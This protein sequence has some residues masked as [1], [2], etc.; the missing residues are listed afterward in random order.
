MRRTLTVVVLIM[1]AVGI[2]KASDDKPAF[3]PLKASKLT[4]DID[5]SGLFVG[6]DK[7][8]GRVDFSMIDPKNDVRL[9]KPKDSQPTRVG[10]LS[11]YANKG[12]GYT[13][14]E[15][16]NMLFYSLPYLPTRDKCPVMVTVNGG[17]MQTRV[18][19]TLDLFS[20]GTTKMPD[21][22]QTVYRSEMKEILT[23]IWRREDIPIADWSR[24]VPYARCRLTL[25]D[26]DHETRLKLKSIVPVLERA[27]HAR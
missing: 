22:G 6:D 18:A 14:M 5:V 17:T 27:E 11:Y 23:G 10:V 19:V 13:F 9:T 4:P 26:D 7:P 8:V 21:G 2:A 1:V 3:P 25:F 24:E 20:I 15:G 12:G 16:E